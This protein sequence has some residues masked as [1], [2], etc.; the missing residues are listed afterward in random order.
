MLQHVVLWWLSSA[1]TLCSQ[2]IVEIIGIAAD[3]ADWQ[4]QGLPDA[5]FERAHSMLKTLFESQGVETVHVADCL[6][7]NPT[8]YPYLFVPKSN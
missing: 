1:A 3:S 8:S 2:V 5:V 7:G 6:A 4:S